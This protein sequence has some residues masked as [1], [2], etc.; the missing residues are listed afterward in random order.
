MEDAGNVIVGRVEPKIYA[1]VTNTI[2]NYLKIGDTYRQVETRLKEW[3]EKFKDLKKVFQSSAR[4]S[5]E[6]FF[7]DYSVHE[8]L[9]GDLGLHRLQ[10]DNGIVSS[11]LYSREFFK[12]AT[13]ADV[14]AAIV[15]IKRDYKEF[16]SKYRFYSAATKLP[17]EYHYP[18][19]GFLEPRDNQKVVIDNFLTAYK[20]GRRNL[21][22]YA[23]MR[24]G[25][26]F[27]ALCCAQKMQ[28]GKGAR[29]IVVVSAKADVCDEWKRTVEGLENFRVDYAFLSSKDL[30]L[31]PDIVTTGLREGKKYV[32]FFNIAR[33]AE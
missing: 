10:K 28:E 5:D 7:R 20:N 18:S 27:T 26:T 33:F 9:E 16:G 31:N 23:V 12:D 6:I 17:S 2:P 8:Y 32:V 15:D 30:Q 1:F 3:K 19:L 29:L 11:E 21:L 22:M 25:K 13:A 14:E 4:V 24:F